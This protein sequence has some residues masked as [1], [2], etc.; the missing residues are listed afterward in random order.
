MKGYVYLN[1]DD[2][3]VYKPWS[4]INVD[5]PAFF[6]ENRVYIIKSW[7]FDTENKSK[8]LEMLTDFN[9]MKIPS[10][11]IS[12]FLS[13]IGHLKVPI[14]KTNTTSFSVASKS[15]NED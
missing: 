2:F 8:F 1:R 10:N 4:Y 5:N 7:M 13:S 12:E 3:L 9:D 11:K 15:T 6:I 14:V